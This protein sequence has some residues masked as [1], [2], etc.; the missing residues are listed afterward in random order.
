M[1]ENEEQKQQRLYDVFKSLA[2]TREEFEGSLNWHENGE[3]SD[4]V[5]GAHG[6]LKSMSHAILAP[7]FHQ[8]PNSFGLRNYEK[9]ED[10]PDEEVPAYAGVARKV[11][12]RQISNHFRDNL[13]D[14]S[15]KLSEKGLEA[16]IEDKEIQSKFREEDA[17]IIGS[18][19]A[20]RN[21]KKNYE[22]Y[23]KTGN[24]AEGTNARE[25]LEEAIEEGGKE[26][27]ENA[28][29]RGFF[30]IVIQL[31]SEEMGRRKAQR[32]KK[33]LNEMTKRALKARAEEAEKRYKEAGN[34]RTVYDVVR[35][36][37]SKYANPETP[38]EFDHAVR[39]VY[40]AS[41]LK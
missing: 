27:R 39:A 22:F 34:G 28:K 16:L 36:A 13:G 35:G 38:Q 31:M 6:K 33:Y 4:K 24:F 25:L 41:K 30:D 5:N 37:I 8:D 40:A 11:L 3:L 23:D 29:K 21:A 19:L 15:A 20:F 12:G 7:F 2:G 14:I 18:Y 10:I 26:V 1:A 17:R 9:P 32:D